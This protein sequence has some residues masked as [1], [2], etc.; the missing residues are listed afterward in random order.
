M[1]H[2][3][4]PTG[5]GVLEWQGAFALELAPALEAVGSG[6]DP[7]L[8]DLVGYLALGRE[9]RPRSYEI[10]VKP[11]FDEHEDNRFLGD[12]IFGLPV[13]RMSDFA[14]AASGDRRHALWLSEH[15]F[16]GQIPEGQYTEVMDAAAGV[17]AIIPKDSPEVSLGGGGPTG[18]FLAATR[19]H[20]ISG[21]LSYLPFL[22]G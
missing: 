4:R 21:I 12:F 17:A 15:L 3:T 18:I 19:K 14:S 10:L 7:G 20:K 22:P 9:Q 2:D 8:W 11:L 5:F 1:C 13:V 6:G 16:S